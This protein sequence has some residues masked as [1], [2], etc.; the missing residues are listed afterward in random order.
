MARWTAP[1]VGKVSPVIHPNEH[2]TDELLRDMVGWENG[3]PKQQAAATAA[4]AS[5]VAHLV[6]E[7]AQLREAIER[8]T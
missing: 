8:S 5:V 1:T 2:V 6:N 3:S 7:V 4:L